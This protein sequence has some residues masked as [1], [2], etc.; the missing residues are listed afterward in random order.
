MKINILIADDEALIREPLG[1]ALSAE[2]MSVELA[3]SG[4]DA[5]ARYAARRPDVI[6]LDLKLGDMD[7][8][9]V[10]RRLRDEDTDTKVILLTAH[11]SVDSAVAAMKAGAYDYIK[12]PFE[13]DEV[14][15]AVRN[16]ASAQ[17]LERR[18]QFYDRRE[19]QRDEDDPPIAE[20]E[21]MRR[22]MSDAEVIARHPV[23][24]ALILGESGT[25]KGLL[26]RRIHYRSE[27]RSGPF[28]ELNC[29]AIPESLLESELFG[30]ERGAFSDARERKLGLVEVADGGTLFLDEIGDLGA[31]AQAK[32]LTFIEERS[33]R[34]VGGNA[35]RQVD[36]RIVAATN[37]ALAA[38][39]GFRRDLLYRLNAVTVVVPPLRERREDIAPLS[40]RFVKLHAREYGKRFHDVSA[41]AAAILERGEWP[42]N[43]RELRAVLNRIVLMEDAE[44]VLPSH[45]PR[46]LLVQAVDVVP[47]S[48][49][50]EGPAGI[51][52][53]HDIELKY[54][55]RVLALCGG[56]K[57]RAA[58]IL[59]ITR[60]TLAKKVGEP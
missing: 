23:P 5:L 47:T 18:V 49:S 4:K 9:D 21:A 24:V 26:A 33:F 8:L 37:R 7:G 41:E 12:K 39:D 51:P 13:L 54:L 31:A 30:H 50:V 1:E 44:T 22:V 28:V 52:S 27:R 2:G 56:N 46:E 20:S 11:G 29:G 17:G 48:L 40:R 6:L 55:R 59:G 19:R 36:V 14:L 15:A 35:I 32:L 60:Q 16:A 42:G 10:L 53:L 45:L 34:R 57:A 3:V 58:Q 38:E 25:G 43:V